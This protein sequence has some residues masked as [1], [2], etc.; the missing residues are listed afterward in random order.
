MADPFI[1]HRPRPTTSG[2][3]TLLLA[4]LLAA[5]G[6]RAQPEIPDSEFNEAVTWFDNLG[7]PAVGDQPFVRIATGRWSQHGNEPKQNTFLAGFLLSDDGREFRVLTVDLK[8]EKFER[9][10]KGTP[11][12]ERVGFVVE[13]L[14]AHCRA[15][16][17]RLRAQNDPPDRFRSLTY[18]P[19]H[20]PGTHLFV[21]AWACE[22][23]G[24]D[25]LALEL[26]GFARSQQDERTASLQDGLAADL[27]HVAMWQL[28]VDFGDPER[29]LTDLL[30][31]CQRL[32]SRF[33]DSAQV[34]R[35]RT[36]RDLLAQMLREERERAPL[37]VDAADAAELAD[38]VF[39]LREQNGHQWSQPGACDVFADPRGD[40]SPAARIVARGYQALPALLPAF[41]DDSFTRC[42]GFHRN[43]YFSHRVLRVR[44]VAAAIGRRITGEPCGS[45]ADAEKLWQAY[46]NKGE[47]T[48]LIESAAQ[49]SAVHLERLLER[50]PADVRPAARKAL[51]GGLDDHAR[52]SL[53]AVLAGVPGAEASALLR[54]ELAKAAGA[55]ATAARA[56]FL[57]G[58]RAVAVDAMIELWNSGA[59]RS[60][61]EPLAA[62]LATC[63]EQRAIAALAADPDRLDYRTVRALGTG[64]A[65]FDSVRLLD[66]SR[67][68]GH[69]ALG[70]AN[71][72]TA[73]AIEE[74]LGSLLGDERRFR[75]NFNGTTDPELRDFAAAALHTR[76]P[77]L[78]DFDFEAPLQQRRRTLLAVTN[79]WRERKGLAPL[80]RPAQPHIPPADPAQL[81]RLLT[82]ARIERSPEARAKTLAKI[83]ALGLGALPTV[84]EQAV[85]AREP[86]RQL[87]WR[88]LGSRIASRVRAIRLSKT[89]APFPEAIEQQA[90]TLAGRRLDVQALVGTLTAFG[91][92]ATDAPDSLQLLVTRADDGT[93][94]VLEFTFGKGTRGDGNSVSYSHSVHAGRRG[95]GN[96]TGAGVR[97][98]AGERQHYDDFST[99]LLRALEA[100]ASEPVD[101]R[102]EMR[103]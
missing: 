75:G 88:E 82:S 58:D 44:D 83:E 18:G 51:A 25:E 98:I 78:Y 7:Y 64:K 31:D 13:S 19:G 79:E 100:P 1:G 42:V 77:K 3:R 22:K 55:R 67:H 17:A 60:A 30:S 99:A 65:W 95:L 11:E 62:F 69:V 46:Q 92:A 81:D 36:T 50:Y 76:F 48:I 49:G 96:T 15:R 10:A 71:D 85:S 41:D 39:R 101:A 102:Y 73:G 90:K 59:A 20:G 66:G 97:H 40:D 21:L 33:P 87:E 38:L 26:A 23:L 27:S 103:F 91:G 34:E 53:V 2:A 12:H 14:R 86:T 16:L 43:F 29:P 54:A 9:T 24:D 72:D 61:A 89:S 6:V 32:L 35:A 68:G 47:R 28:I 8:T 57:R 4:T 63:G 45:R 37:A 74:L 80:P 93:G 84:N 5:T 94:V 52:R 56:L 70:E